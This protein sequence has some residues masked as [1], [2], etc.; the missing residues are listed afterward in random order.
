MTG[1]VSLGSGGFASV[2]SSAYRLYKVAGKP[3]LAV[4]DF[5]RAL[6][7]TALKRLQPS[8]WKRAAYSWSLHLSMLLGLDD[9]LSLAVDSPLGSNSELSFNDWRASMRGLLGY[10][11][12]H[13]AV[14]WPPQ[15]E[16]ERIYV[17][18]FDGLHA[19][20]FA[21]LSFGALD[22]ACLEHEASVL[23]ELG[24][25]GAEHFRVPKVLASGRDRSHAFIVMEPLPA[26]VRPL[27]STLR[28]YP[29]SSVDEIAGPVRTVGAEELSTLSWWHD[30]ESR[31][32]ADVRPFHD[33][34]MGMV[35][36][37]LRVCRA[38]GDL[39]PHNIVRDGRGLWIFDWEESCADAP[40]QTDRLGFELSIHLPDI[41][42]TPQHWVRVLKN[43]HLHARQPRQK[44]DLMM[45]L[46]FRHAKGIGDATALMQHWTV[47]P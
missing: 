6:R 24:A 7:R 3:I 8:T 1:R 19:V 12:L 37:G 32:R 35:G 9:V 34:M 28:A 44:L 46:A 5:P 4:P 18:L 16:R 40:L 20:G 42:A 27:K 39:S 38:H 13:A 11:N 15:V 26:S 10:P 25:G 22:A 29:A 14:I 45:A 21:K 36:S 31:L 2:G 47:Q 30:Y 23:R 33:E 43:K 41:M 17:H